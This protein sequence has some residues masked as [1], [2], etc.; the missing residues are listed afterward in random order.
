MAQMGVVLKGP[1]KEGTIGNTFPVKGDTNQTGNLHYGHFWG[2]HFEQLPNVEVGYWPQPVA[3]CNG[4][5]I[6]ACT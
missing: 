1:C 4:A 5:D 3:P 6:K 2:R